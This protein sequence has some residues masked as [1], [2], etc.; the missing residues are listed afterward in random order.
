MIEI[1]KNPVTEYAQFVVNWENP[2]AAVSAY[3]L[4]LLIV[5]PRA[6]SHSR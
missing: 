4:D 1:W 3:A 2:G 6:T 5:G